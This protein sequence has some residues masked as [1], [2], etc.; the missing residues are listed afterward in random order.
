[1]QRILETMLCLGNAGMSQLFIGVARAAMIEDG[2]NEML[3]LIAG[4][5]L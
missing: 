2:C 1:V 3:G 5:R 4:A